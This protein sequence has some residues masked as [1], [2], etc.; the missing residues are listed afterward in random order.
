[1]KK[2]FTSLFA[3]MATTCL[4]AWDFKSGDLFYKITNN[5]VPYTVEVTYQLDNRTNYSGLTSVDIPKTVAHNGQTYTV[6]SIGANA[7]RACATL[8]SITVPSSVQHFGVNAFYK[9]KSLQVTNFMGDIAQ[10]CAMR[11]KGPYSNPICQ[12]HR[13]YIKDKELR[14][15]VLPLVDTIPE[16]LFDGCTSIKSISIPAGVKF[17]GKNA[18]YGCKSLSTTNFQGDI[19]EWCMIRFDGS[20]SNPIGQSHNLLIN[21]QEITELVIPNTIDSIGDGQFDCCASFNSIV[22]PNSV[23]YIGEGAFYKCSSVAT[24]TVPSSVTMIQERAFSGCDSLVALTVEEGNTV[25]DSRNNCNAIIETSSNTLVAGCAATVIPENVTKIGKHAF[26]YHTLLHTITIPSSVTT[27][28]DRAFTRCSALASITL[29]DGLEFINH[30]AFAG[31]EL[32]AN[33]TLP[34]TVTYIG[35]AAFRQCSALKSIIIPNNVTSIKRSAFSYCT[36]LQFLMLSTTLMNIEEQAFRNCTSLVSVTLPKSVITLDKYVFAN[37]SS[38]KQVMYEGTLE[39][40]N[41]VGKSKNWIE[42]SPISYVQCKNG[43]VKF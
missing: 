16:Y 18:F 35:E 31:C 36:S 34:T 43:K 22:I 9:C 42:R 5:S 40:W 28:D 4:W 37:C 3:I 27:I 15:V 30:S 24:I 21:N 25:Y 33:I 8:Q 7:F 32:L 29:S 1:M 17:F 10:W 6:N 26:S 14:E 13:F 2:I 11:F 12:S 23:K 38:L 41:R 20:F 39:E 19:A